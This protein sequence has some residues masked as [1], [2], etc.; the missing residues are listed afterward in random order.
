MHEQHRPQQ[1]KSDP[2]RKHQQSSLPCSWWR[3]SKVP[4]NSF[5]LKFL[6]D[7]VQL[8]RNWEVDGVGMPKYKI[9]LSFFRAAKRF[10][11]EERSDDWRLIM[12]VR[13]CKIEWIITYFQLYE[14]VRSST[15][16]IYTDSSSSSQLSPS[17]T[18]NCLASASTSAEASQSA[19][20]SAKY[21]PPPLCY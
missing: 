1:Q 16:K 5:S 3:N 9:Y 21:S 4:Q 11:K 14:T 10:P 12:N 13:C 17:T 15:T 2:H 7:R 6:C 8:S 19:S 18:W 20:D